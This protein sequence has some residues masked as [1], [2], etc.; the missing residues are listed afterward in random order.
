MTDEE[1]QFANCI[2]ADVIYKRLN[3]ESEYTTKPT[4]ELQRIWE[5]LFEE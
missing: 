4:V 5:E 1:L 3:D 2:G